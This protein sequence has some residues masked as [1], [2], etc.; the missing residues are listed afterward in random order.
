MSVVSNTL[1][2]TFKKS[3]IP[4]QYLNKKIMLEFERKKEPHFK[5]LYLTFET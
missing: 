1:K 3:A 2:I 5:H 4:I